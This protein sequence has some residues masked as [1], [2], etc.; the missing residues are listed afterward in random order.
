MK[1]I[2][3]FH[4]KVYT[5]SNPLVKR[6]TDSGV[7]LMVAL[8]DVIEHSIRNDEKIDENNK[9]VFIGEVIKAA[10]EDIFDPKTEAIN[11]RQQIEVWLNSKDEKVELQIGK[12][13]TKQFQ[14]DQ[15]LYKIKLS[16]TQL[17]KI[18]QKK[19]LQADF[20]LF[21]DKLNTRVKSRKLSWS[22]ILELI[23]LYLSE[24]EE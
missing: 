14:P 6:F 11:L 2:F 15:Y 1:A 12:K 21:Q 19:E 22:K 10:E 24:Y 20:N 13:L 3:D 18:F 4:F 16:K 7:L 23:D 5:S 9:D 8:S 17:L